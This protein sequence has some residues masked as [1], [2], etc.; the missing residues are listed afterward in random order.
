M[1]KHL[2]SVIACAFMNAFFSIF[3]FIFDAIIPEHWE[4]SDNF[5]LRCCNS[6]AAYYDLVRSDAL[7]YVY[8]SGNS[9]CNSA[10]Y[11]DYV[12]HKSELTDNSQGM[13]RIYRLTSHFAIAGTIA[14]LAFWLINHGR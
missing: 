2:G 6:F 8:L 9:Y 11:C 13:N 5:C 14:V 12:V 3:D 1:C 7:T 10:R 4:N